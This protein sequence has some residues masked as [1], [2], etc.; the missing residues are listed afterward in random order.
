MKHKDLTHKS[1]KRKTKRTEKRDDASVANRGNVLT[2]ILVI[3]RIQKKT[4]K[5]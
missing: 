1:K 2:L 3:K 5:N 4:I